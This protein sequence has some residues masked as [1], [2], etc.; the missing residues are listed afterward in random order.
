LSVKIFLALIAFICIGLYSI[1]YHDLKLQSETITLRQ[2]DNLDFEVEV[3][4]YFEGFL[5]YP[6]T[7]AFPE[8]GEYQLTNFQRFWNGQRVEVMKKNSKFDTSFVISGNSYPFLHV[9]TYPISLKYKNISKNIYT[10]TPPII[11]IGKEPF[12]KKGRLI[13]YILLTGSQWRGGIDKI[14]L[15]VYLKNQ[16]CTRLQIL[17]ESYYGYCQD[18]FIWISTLRNVKPFKN[19]RL[20]LLE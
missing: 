19:F 3:T 7:V 6:I 14:E 4:Y 11:S 16:D 17:P 15:K 9:S 18:G 5:F 10:F 1:S 2:L 20:V 8:P 12:L 13:E